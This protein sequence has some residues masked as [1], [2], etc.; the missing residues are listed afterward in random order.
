MAFWRAGASTKSALAILAIYNFNL[1]T[2]KI[3]KRYIY[4][5]DQVSKSAAN[6]RELI[7]WL[8]FASI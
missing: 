8:D 6:R 3:G 1:R 2:T 7:C 5:L 4:S